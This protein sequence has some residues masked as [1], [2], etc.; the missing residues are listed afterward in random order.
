MTT[1]AVTGATGHLGRLV[2]QALLDRGVD[3]GA[4]VAAV[5][6]PQKA[7][8]LLGRGVQVR[9]ADYDRPETL[10]TALAGVDRLL[11][12]SGN[13]VGSRLAQHR[14]VIEAAKAAGVGFV[15]YTSVLRADTTPIRLAAEH[16]ATEEALAASGLPYSFLRN[17]WYLE[18]YTS[19]LPTVRATGAFLGSAGQGRIAA[20][21]RADYAEAA[22]AVLTAGSARPVYELGGDQPFTMAELAAEVSR[23]LGAEI[24]YTDVP[25][26]QLVT[27][28][29]GAGVPRDFAEILADTDVHVREH[30]ALDNPGPDLRELI[31]RPTTAPA[32]AIAEALKR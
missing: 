22:A 32:E 24:G 1:I 25:A 13:A 18:N 14:A 5:R 9:E 19:Q 4:I 21:T 20:A 3:A 27:I 23:Q 28:L 29:T 17:G 2:V 7:A 10:A 11:L 15:A 31:G 8:D 26:E 6:T 30:S 12:V 16:R